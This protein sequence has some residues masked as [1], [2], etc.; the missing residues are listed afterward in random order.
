MVSVAHP[1]TISCVSWQ[2]CFTMRHSQTQAHSKVH[3]PVESVVLIFFSNNLENFDV[4]VSSKWTSTFIVCR[5]FKQ[6]TSITLFWRLFSLAEKS[7]PVFVLKF[8]KMYH[9]IMHSACNIDV[10]S[11]KRFYNHRTC[12]LPDL[13]ILRNVVVVVVFFFF[14][15]K[16][17]VAM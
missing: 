8:E 2:L 16:I 10:I 17:G 1:V 3:C 7:K 11:E 5:P 12:R 6:Y 13:H 14:F 9:I 15:C 4:H